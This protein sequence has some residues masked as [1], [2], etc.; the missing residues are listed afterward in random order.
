[1]IEIIE[2]NPNVHGSLSIGIRD[3]YDFF[4][5]YYNEKNRNPML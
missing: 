3:S 5:N 2:I 4:Q 1:M